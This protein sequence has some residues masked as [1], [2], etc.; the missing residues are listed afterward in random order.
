MEFTRS[1]VEAKKEEEGE[2][3]AMNAKC[4]DTRVTNKVCQTIL[5]DCLSHL[6]C[7]CMIAF[8]DL[9]IQYKTSSGYAKP[10]F[11]KCFLG[12]VWICGFEI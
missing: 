8:I 10:E 5:S 2:L 6:E 7:C 3:E 11:E 9:R 12:C 1:W 4:Y